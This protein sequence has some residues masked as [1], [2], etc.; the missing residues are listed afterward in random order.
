MHPPTGPAASPGHSQACSGCVQLL[1]AMLN[2][3][4][5]GL[6]QF[7]TPQDAHHSFHFGSVLPPGVLFPGCYSLLYGTQQVLGSFYPSDNLQSD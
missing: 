4:K 5:K 6:R 3:Q 2:P 7:K 1:T